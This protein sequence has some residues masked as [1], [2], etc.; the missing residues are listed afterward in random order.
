MKKKTSILLVLLVIIIT[1]LLFSLTKPL[2][3][4][5]SNGDKV[6]QELFRYEQDLKVNSDKIEE[7]YKKDV[8]KIVGDY[9]DKKELNKELVE[10]TKN[11]LLELTVTKDLQSVHFSLVYAM[12][13]M[14]DY[15]NNGDVRDKTTSLNI[16]E[17]MQSNY[18]WLN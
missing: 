10:E 13:K 5:S 9:L 14:D 1:L 2:F 3:K 18:D 15:F 6:Q 16:I 17:E 7:T 8:R 11:R 4:E 12:D